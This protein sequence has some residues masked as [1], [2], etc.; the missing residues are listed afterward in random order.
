VFL[1]CCCCCWCFGCCCCCLMN[2][3]ALFCVLLLMLLLLAPVVF[4]FV[5]ILFLTMS[6]KIHQY[7][8]INSKMCIYIH[9]YIHI[10]DI[11]NKSFAFMYDYS[12]TSDNKHKACF[13]L[14]SKF[15]YVLSHT[16]FYLYSLST[17]T[18]TKIVYFC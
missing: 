13:D 6:N 4:A 3:N 12:L 16:I 8:F 2:K 11:K 7:T 10:L 15:L 14:K 1:F 17:Y 9:T 18:T 5:F